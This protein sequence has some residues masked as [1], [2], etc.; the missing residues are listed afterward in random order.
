MLT[1]A[2]TLLLTVAACVA[3]PSNIARPCRVKDNKCV[4]DNLAANS[5]C[6]PNVRGFLP[7][8]YTINSFK[9][10]TPYF[11]AT[12]IDNNLVIRNHNSCFVSEFFFNVDSDAA[13]LTIDCPD[14]DFES[15]RTLIQHSSFQEDTTYNYSYR[16][17][18]PLVRLTVNLPHANALDLCSSFTF[19]D[20]TEL[21]IFLINPNDEKTENFLA[22]DLTLLNIYERETFFY[23]ANQLAR[24][25]INSLICNFGCDF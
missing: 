16:G 11:N 9:F 15:T 3:V 24:Y 8:E 20:V 2:V 7:A 25:Y 19:A 18:Y 4:R 23:R 13:V 6:N 5:R 22:T 12:Y 14:L 17:R 10:D 1:K 21:P